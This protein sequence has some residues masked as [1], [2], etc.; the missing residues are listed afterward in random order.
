MVMA[1]EHRST[2][3]FSEFPPRGGSYEG[4]LVV[5]GPRSFVEIHDR[6]RRFG[7]FGPGEDSQPLTLVGRLAKE[8]Y[9]LATGL[10][11][12]SVSYPTYGPYATA[13]LAV[14]GDLIYSSDELI[15]EEG[16]ALA[17]TVHV[18]IDWLEQWA[19][20][21]IRTKGAGRYSGFRRLFTTGTA[22][23]Q[24]S[25]D[26]VVVGRHQCPDT[27][28]DLGDGVTLRFESRLRYGSGE[29]PLHSTIVFQDAVLV[30]ESQRPR[31]LTE[32]KR[33]AEI[34]RELLRFVYAED[35]QIRSVKGSRRDRLREYKSVFGE[36]MP[37]VHEMY[38][39]YDG[40]PASGHG[41]PLFRLDDIAERPEVIQAWF[42]LNDH[43]REVASQ[44]VG[45]VRISF[46]EAIV[47]GLLFRFADALTEKRSL[48]ADVRS[49]L[50]ASD[51]NV[52]AADLRNLLKAYSPRRPTK[53]ALLMDDLGLDEW[54]IDTRMWGKK[55]RAFR[56]DG[57]VHGTKQ[58]SQ[59]A[60]RAETG[61]VALE[62]LKLKTLQDLGFCSNERREIA[63]RQTWLLRPTSVGAAE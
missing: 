59:G 63:E 62:L 9:V 10:Y 40:E 57:S 61:Q 56:N 33:S 50:E 38:C 43:H 24:E 32:L 58:A 39:H 4:Q 15:H 2:G 21:P 51:E 52:A 31:P 53:Y 8:H 25:P 36:R 44:L 47:V 35:C 49:L 30:V 45:A 55:L 16:E 48:L 23:L 60:E 37:H 42:D 18:R 41:E 54:G 22:M 1:A 20:P 17:D 12:E 26:C 34:F 28:V 11:E 6:N 27:Q 13:T 29:R 5:G 7:M 19:L 14:R 3:I 46:I